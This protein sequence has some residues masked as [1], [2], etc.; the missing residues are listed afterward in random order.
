MLSEKTLYGSVVQV[1]VNVG[2]RREQASTYVV[3]RFSAEPACVRSRKSLLDTIGDIGWN[4]PLHQRA[5]NQLAVA[6]LREIARGLRAGNVLIQSNH[7]IEVAKL[8]LHGNA[9]GQINEIVIQERHAR[10]E[11]VRHREF[12][13][14]G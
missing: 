1:T 11:A 9:A 3:D 13:L 7:L 4:I 14:H 12:V 2:T 10:F 6:R 5:H 8:V